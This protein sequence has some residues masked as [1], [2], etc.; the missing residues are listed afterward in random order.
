VQSIVLLLHEPFERTYHLLRN[1]GRHG[2]RFAP[3]LISQSDW[4][5]LAHRLYMISDLSI[6]G[7]ASTCTFSHSTVH[8]QS[9]LAV[10]DGCRTLHCPIYTCR[11]GV[12]VLQ[13]SNCVVLMC[14]WLPQQGL[15]DSFSAYLEHSS[16]SCS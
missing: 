10:V 7:Y 1:A 12:Q 14:I 9:T 5:T 13:R 3:L 4:S 16:E 11:R 2:K 15:A 6:Y 8:K